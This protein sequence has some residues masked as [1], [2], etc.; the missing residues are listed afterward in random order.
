VTERCETIGRPVRV[1]LPSGSPLLGTATAID[2]EGRLIVETN[3][4]V[5]AVAAGDVTHL[6]Y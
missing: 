1:E 3:T 4:R 5:T 6:R 2:Q